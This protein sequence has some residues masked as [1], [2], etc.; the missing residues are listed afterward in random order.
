MIIF[1]GSMDEKV[2]E[3]MIDRLDYKENHDLGIK[4]NV[5][6]VNELLNEL[7]KYSKSL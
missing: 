1:E 4:K 5:D 2:L 6:K 7:N 3:S